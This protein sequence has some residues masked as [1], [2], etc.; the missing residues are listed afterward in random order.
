M[1]TVRFR[2]T[3]TAASTPCGCGGTGSGR[4][5]CCPTVVHGTLMIQKQE[6]HCAR[7][8][9]G[10]T[11]SAHLTVP[12]RLFAHWSAGDHDWRV[13]TGFFSVHATRHADASVLTV[14]VQPDCSAHIPNPAHSMVEGTDTHEDRQHPTE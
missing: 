7:R 14:G 10:E 5:W 4:V 6:R 11:V 1:P 2:Q 8:L 9:P 13:E 12:G 3:E